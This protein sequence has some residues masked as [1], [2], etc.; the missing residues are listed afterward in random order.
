MDKVLKLYT[1]KF[2]SD[3][4]EY[5]NTFISNADC[6]DWLFKNI[7]LIDIPDKEI[8]EIYYFRYWVLRK[9]IKNTRT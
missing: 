7:P 8:E 2:N 3:D 9:H 1:D 6:F 5:T 4:R